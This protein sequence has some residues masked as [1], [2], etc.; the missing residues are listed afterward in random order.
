MIA[1]AS[2]CEVET[3]VVLGRNLCLLRVS[4]QRKSTLGRT[5]ADDIRASILGICKNQD[6]QLSAQHRDNRVPSILA[7]HVDI[8][9]RRCVFVSTRRG[10]EGA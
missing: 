5:V 6:S 9:T 2:R 3:R 7:C 1:T 4:P 10:A 8:H